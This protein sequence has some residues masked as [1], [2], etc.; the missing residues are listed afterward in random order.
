MEKTIIL[1]RIK[2]SPEI[3]LVI[4]GR[5]S[6]KSIRSIKLPIRRVFKMVWLPI[7]SPKAR[8]METTTIPTTI[9]DCPMVSGDDI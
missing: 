4:S 1:R 5:K 3:K 2:I 6:R 7:G 8:S 9:L